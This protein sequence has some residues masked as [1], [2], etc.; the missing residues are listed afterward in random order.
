MTAALLYGEKFPKLLIS[1]TEA[2]LHDH[3][4]GVKELAYEMG[5]SRITLHR[6]IKAKYMMSASRFIRQM[7]LYRAREI[8]SQNETTVTETAFQCGFNS[9]AYFDKC[10]RDLFGHTP[11]ET[12]EN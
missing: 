11:G 2:R 4:F 8:L 6:R 10:F 7:R 1:I 9:V 5:I 3:G 12:K